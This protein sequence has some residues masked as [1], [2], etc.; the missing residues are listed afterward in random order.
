M[1]RYKFEQIAI[2]STEKKKPVEADKETY[3]GL[4]HLD[5]GCLRVS[6]W[7]A[8]VAPIGDKLIMRKGDVLF[9]R[10]RAYQK[11][12]AI[13]P[14]DG[15]FSAHG[16]VLRP[17][18]DVVTERFFPFFISSDIFLDAAIK[19]SVGSLSPTINWRDLKELEFNLPP[20]DEQDSLADELWAFEETKGAYN[21]LL[22][23]TE[24]LVKSQFI[25]MFGHGQ[26]QRRPLDD[27]CVR[28]AQNGFYRKGAEKDAN[29]PIIKMKELFAYESMDQ[30]IETDSVNMT[31]KERENFKLTPN[32]L[33]FGRRS[34][35]IEGAGKCR[36][37]GN[38]TNMI[39]FESSLLRITLDNEI[40]LPRYVQAWFESNEGIEAIRSIRAVTTIAGI[41]GSD[42]KQVLVPQPPIELQKRFAAIAESSDKS[43]FALQQNIERLEMCRNALMQKA[44][45]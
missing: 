16:M 43:K 18:L 5:T 22:A 23:T 11:K 14:F 38:V 19:I 33:L 28:S 40:L 8:E 7:G 12:V 4:E 32:D 3:L 29:T 42:L 45:G 34:L 31:D 25:E 13:A 21:G 35:V 9:G 24:A 10:R 20:I 6:R 37:V 15:I 2:N 44:F 36:R 26:H 41:K 30:A 39:A 1:P 27:M 17:R